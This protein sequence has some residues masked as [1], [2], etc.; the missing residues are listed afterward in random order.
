[1]LKRILVAIFSII[2]GGFFL[3]FGADISAGIRSGISVCGDVVIPSLFPFMILAE[4]IALSGASDTLSKPLAPFTRLIFGLPR[5]TAAPIFLSFISGYPVGASLTKRLYD[6]GKITRDDAEK[7]LTF[8]VNSSPAM[9]I[10]AVGMGMLGSKEYGYVLFIVHILASVLN[11]I[12]FSRIILNYGKKKVVVIANSQTSTWQ[13]AKQNMRPHAPNPT[14]T[15][16]QLTNKTNQAQHYN[17]ADAFVT[18]TA[19]ASISMLKICGC[20][21]L[22]AG[23][24]SSV[25]SADILALIL[26]VTVG[27]NV[28][29]GYGLNVISA[30]IGFGGISVIMQ[31][32]TVSKGLIRPH[33]LIFSRLTHAAISYGL[34][35]VAISLLPERT[36]AVLSTGLPSSSSFSSVTAPASAAMLLLS[37]VVMFSAKIA[38][39][40]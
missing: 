19:D 11:G 37:V 10:F 33:I 6:S 29:V 16:I 7:M 1:M 20:V 23:I 18:A 15:D 28:A 14:Q 30:V 8:T 13:S 17:I 32:M 4:F 24:V 26:D 40:E 39:A 3:I 22:F 2:I 38:N 36:I 31:I 12:L 35:S 25:N 27:C 34:C 5:A 21:I 9:L